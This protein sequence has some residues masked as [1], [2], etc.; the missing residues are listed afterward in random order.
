MENTL[1]LYHYNSLMRWSLSQVSLYFS[2]LDALIFYRESIFVG[3]YIT[4]VRQ[5]CGLDSIKLI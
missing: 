5:K 1:G 3:D 4:N 2:F